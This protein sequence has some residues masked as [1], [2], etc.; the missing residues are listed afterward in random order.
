MDERSTA[1]RS[2]EAILADWRQAER[3]RDDH[4]TDSPAWIDADRRV[5]ALRQEFHESV[6][7]LDASQETRPVMEDVPA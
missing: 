1:H 3:Q 2:A 4:H 5:E 6:S 7:E